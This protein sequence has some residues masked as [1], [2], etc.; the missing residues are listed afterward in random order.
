MK[1]ER[2]PKIVC[3]DLFFL[4]LVILCAIGKRKREDSDQSQRNIDIYPMKQRHL[5][6]PNPAHGNHKKRKEYM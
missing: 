1:G 6:S 5:M 3:N 4:K 2:S